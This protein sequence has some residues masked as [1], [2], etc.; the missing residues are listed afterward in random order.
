MAKKTARS[1]SAEQVAQKAK[2]NWKAVAAAPAAD[3]PYRSLRP[4]RPDAATPELDVL[5][6]KYFGADQVQTTKAKKTTRPKQS[7]MVVMEPKNAADTSP[8]RK[9]VL[10]EDGKI[11][12]EQG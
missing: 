11:V 3:N 10:V 6:R 5:Y 2:P 7:K 4:A 9:T 1:L 12:G 8:G